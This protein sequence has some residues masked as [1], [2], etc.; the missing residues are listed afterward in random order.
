MNSRTGRVA[1]QQEREICTAARGERDLCCTAGHM[2]TAL[3]QNYVKR[4]RKK[5]K[6]KRIVS[7]II[8]K[9]KLLSNHTAGIPTQMS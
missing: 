7:K 2:R 1:Q 3:T 6:G 8:V 4:R 9:A 5:G